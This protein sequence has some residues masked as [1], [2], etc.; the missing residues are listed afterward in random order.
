MMECDHNERTL[1]DI[2][3]VLEYA[4]L[5][6]SDVKPTVQCIYFSQ[7]LDNQSFK[8]LELNDTV[9]ETLTNGEK[10][11]IRGSA[12]DMAILCTSSATFEIK[13]AEISNSMLITPQLAIGQDVEDSGAQNIQVAKVIS[14]MNNYYELRP[15]KPRI[16][17]LKKLLEENMFSGREC[18]EDEQHQGHKYSLEDLLDIVQGSESEIKESLK[19]L[20]ACQIE[21]LWRVL[22]FNFLSQVLNHIIQLCEENDWLSTGIQLEECVETLGQLFPKYPD[23][24]P[25]RTI[26]TGNHSVRINEAPLYIQMT[27]KE[28]ITH[29][30]QCYADEMKSAPSQRDQDPEDQPMEIDA[31]FFTFNE[32]KVCQFF[33]E[34]IL[35][36]S[37]KFNFKEFLRVWEQTVPQGMKTSLSQLEGIA[38]IEKDAVPEVIGYYPVEDLPEDVGERFNQLFKTREKWSLADISPYIRDMTTKKL[39][40]GG[41]L[42]KYARASM[43]NGVKVF[44]SRRPVI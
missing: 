14:V 38:L 22:D 44:S 17:K 1:E 13:E 2:N 30:I 11:V 23:A 42:T 33:A 40:V 3:T 5:E 32:D 35:R 34:L 25:I 18:E 6:A 16:S 20:K 10:V 39:D 15:C 43:M 24:S 41:L 19:K 21:G 31:K 29:I 37:G 26:L 28:V 12:E 7:Q 27:K 4:K 9:L 36:S 8:L